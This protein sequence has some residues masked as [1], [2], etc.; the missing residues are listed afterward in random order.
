MIENDKPVKI[1][2]TGSYGGMN[3]GMRLY[4]SLFW[5]KLDAQLRQRLLYSA[6]IQQIHIEDIK[7]KRV[8]QSGH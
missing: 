7:L 8:Y 6:V 4:F 5:R 3:M 2:I 1:G